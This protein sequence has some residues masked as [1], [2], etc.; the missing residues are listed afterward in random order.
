MNIRV[1]LTYP[2]KDGTE[3][4]FRAPVDCSQV[5]GLKVYYPGASKEFALADAHGNNVGNIPHLFAE[6]VAV[7]VILDVSTGMA[8]VQNADTNAYLE[9]RFAEISGCSTI[10]LQK[11]GEDIEVK[12]ASG[13]KLRSLTIYGKTIQ[14]GTPAPDA[15]VELVIPG[16]NGSIVV[17]VTDGT[18]NN[19]QSLAVSTPNGLPGIKVKTGGNYT[20]ANG[21][22]WFCDEIDFAR[23][24]YV[25]RVGKVSL[26]GTE[27]WSAY[28]GGAF[29][30]NA[31]TDAVIPGYEVVPEMYCTHLEPISR[32]NV[33]SGV[34]GVG[35]ASAKQ[36]VIYLG[37]EYTTVNDVKNYLAE[38]YAEGMPLTVL[39][40]TTTETEIPLSAEELAAYAVLHTYKPTT[41]ISN[42]YNAYMKVSYVADTKTYID[43]KFAGTEKVET[44]NGEVEVA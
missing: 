37:T 33:L 17:S 8:F 27:N 4:V 15:P 25:Q 13:L 14:D 5:T 3:V 12:D 10:M 44:Y 42:D 35:V 16:D 11:T 26:T 22:R 34:V 6:N 31:F 1:D 43:N 7:K 23:G 36:I 9:G 24:V 32:K 21:Q 29:I 19:I 38:Q 2:I 39:Y 30:R 28:S 18:T 40:R 20:D 41:V